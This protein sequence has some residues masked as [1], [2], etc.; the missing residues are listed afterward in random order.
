MG[1]CK[2]KKEEKIR[3]FKKDLYYWNTYSGVT[4][5]VFYVVMSKKAWNFVNNSLNFRLCSF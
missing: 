5:T 3:E 1:R 2:E 4:K